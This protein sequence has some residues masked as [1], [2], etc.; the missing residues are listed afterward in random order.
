MDRSDTIQE[1]GFALDKL[2]R[3][4]K[5][6][7]AGQFMTS[8][9]TAIPTDEQER[10][11]LSETLSLVAGDLSLPSQILGEMGAWWKLLAW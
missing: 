4:G 9:E 10:W 2:I 5:F 3:D 7:T 11:P 1:L 6:Y 8:L